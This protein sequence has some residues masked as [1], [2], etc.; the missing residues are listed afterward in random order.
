MRQSRTS[1][2]PSRALKV[3]STS[4]TSFGLSAR[5]NESGS[6]AARKRH[7]LTQEMLVATEAGLLLINGYRSYEFHGV[8]LFL[9]GTVT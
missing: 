9:V 8:H 3:E 5:K 1:I 2:T 7:L 6:R 4:G